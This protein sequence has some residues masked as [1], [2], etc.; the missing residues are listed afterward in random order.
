MVRGGAGIYY[1]L[2]LGNIAN[3]FSYVYPFFALKTTANVPFPLSNAARTPP[4]PGVDPPS[5]FFLSDPN[6][7]LPY[8]VQ[9][10]GTWEQVLG[11]GQAVTVGYV[12]ASGHRL[13]MAQNYFPTRLPEWPT[14]SSQLVIQRNLGFASYSALQVQYQRRLNH[15]VQALVSYTLARSRDN[16]STDVSPTPPT[17]QADLLAREY[18]PSDFDVR[19][20]LSA[21]LTYELPAPSRSALLRALS[22]GWGLDMLFRYQSAFPVNPTAG[23]LFLPNGTL[24]TARPDLVPS[25][26][27]YVNDPTVPGGRRFNRAAFAAPAPGQQGNFPRNGLRGFPISQVDLA[28]RREFKLREFVSLQLRAE[29]FNLFNHPNFGAATTSITDPLFGRSTQMLNRSLGGL[30]ALYQMGGPRSVQLAA[31]VRF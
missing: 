28:L 12:G 6:L 25:Q 10:N 16:A 8:T 9:W 21:A 23:S 26:P 29:V 27:L 31:R 15:G 3:G 2:G 19:H 14:T 4:T 22:R 20:V 24:Y 1:D 11:S 18:A 13:L 5:A 7:R 30:N 17:S